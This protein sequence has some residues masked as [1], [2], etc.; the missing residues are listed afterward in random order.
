MGMRGTLR[1]S[2]LMPVVFQL[3]LMGKPAVCHSSAHG[4][5]PVATAHRGHDLPA[6]DEHGNDCSRP[7]S[8]RDCATMLAC[9]MLAEPAA[10][11]QPPPTTEPEGVPTTPALSA[12]L[13]YFA[14]E[15]PPP[16]F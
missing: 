12:Q 16:R 11:D 9:A 14:P 8:D 7:G 13:R 10:A 5:S 6:T 3:L 1:L 4:M 15:P 2:A